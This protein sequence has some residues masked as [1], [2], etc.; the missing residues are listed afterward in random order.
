MSVTVKIP[1][2]A[3]LSIKVEVSA[4]VNITPFV[5]K[6]EVDDF[7]LNEVGNLLYAENPELL[8]DGKGMFWRVPVVYTLPSHGKLGTVGYLLVDVQSGEICRSLAVVEEIRRNA[9]ALYH[10]HASQTA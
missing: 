2:E 5:A 3:E 10:T 8:V 4:R 6:Q 9:Q 7:L 1:E